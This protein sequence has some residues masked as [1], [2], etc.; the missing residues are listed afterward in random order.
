[1]GRQ[2]ITLT[3]TNPAQSLQ[4][5]SDDEAEYLIVRN[6]NPVPVYVRIGSPEIPTELNYDIIIAPNFR[7]GINV[8]GREFGLR[9]GTVNGNPTLIVGATVVE[10]I[11]NEPPPVFG[12]VPIA[13]ASLAVSDA[14][15]LSAY[16]FPLYVSS[17][18][19]IDLLL[20]GGL[21]VFVSPDAASGQAILQI[22]VSPDNTNVALW[23]IYGQW[24]LWP[25]VASVLTIP[26]VARYARVLINAT[27]IAGEAAIAGR[28]SLRTV[29]EEVESTTFAPNSNSISKAYNVPALQPTG[30]LFVYC[31]IGLPSI[32]LRLQN[33]S[34]TAG[35]LIWRTGP[36]PTGPWALV[37]YRE[38]LMS[39]LYGAIFRS[40]GNLDAFVQVEVQ[41]LAAAGA[42][43]G[44]LSATIQ[45]SPDLTQYLQSIYH[46]LGDS[47]QPVQ[48]NQNIYAELDAIRLQTDQVEPTL[49]NILDALGGPLVGAAR[50]TT[51][52]NAISAAIG[53]GNLT[54]ILNAINS[55]VGVGNLTTL[56][57]NG[58]ASLA[59]IDVDTSTIIARLD[60]L[61]AQPNT[62]VTPGPINVA[63][64]AAN[65]WQKVAD[66]Y[67]VNG[68]YTHGISI[69]YQ[70]QGPM[71]DNFFCQ[72]AYGTAAAVTSAI[73]GNTGAQP[74]GM[75]PE[76]LFN[77]GGKAGGILQS[78]GLTSLW[79]YS[80]AAPAYFSL[81]ISQR[82]P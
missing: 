71:P 78:G 35:Q 50:I 61:I 79:I 20:W 39:G 54:T 34:G 75:F 13:G 82:A 57:T 46:V 42:L 9:L 65:V 43:I 74:E 33:T 12:G 58:N 68:Y 60:T 19:G 40:V 4:I 24:A 38:Q 32:G 56:I 49:A 66:N 21:Q 6:D 27:T 15:A 48:V 17:T 81:N 72:V 29:L 67:F 76:Y 11:Y 55:A 16:S 59:A 8:T 36:T 80:G 41:N 52:L 31:S 25:N 5:R 69:A 73:Y 70:I 3:R 26:R 28:V 1:M 22:E 10:A 64:V 77:S 7:E 47:Q 63:V 45:E 18:N 30:T 2:R 51:F 14:F 23:R 53:G 44:N 62:S 37:A